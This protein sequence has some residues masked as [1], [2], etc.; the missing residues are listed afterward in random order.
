MPS[1]S[2]VHLL[3]DVPVGLGEDA[4]DLAEVE[5]AEVLAGDVLDGGFEIRHP[6]HLLPV[7]L[8]AH[9]HVHAPE[10]LCQGLVPVVGRGRCG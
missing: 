3:P 8:H 5:L 1:Q 7:E 6:D 4:A 9:D 2:V 10:D